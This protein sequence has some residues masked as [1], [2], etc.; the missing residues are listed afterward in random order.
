MEVIN[1]KFEHLVEVD[2]KWEHDNSLINTTYIEVDEKSTK[3]VK[4]QRKLNR[5]LNEKY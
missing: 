5:I 3:S 1:V 2:Y 4:R